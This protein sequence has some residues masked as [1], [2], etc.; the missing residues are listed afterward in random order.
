MPSAALPPGS[1]E[2]RPL[3]LL[4]VRTKP[5]DLPWLAET[6]ARFMA[7][8]EI[9]QV[10][11]LSNALWRLGQERFDSVLLDLEVKDRAALEECRRQ[12]GQVAGLPVLNLQ[13]DGERALQSVLPARSRMPDRADPGQE[14]ARPRRTVRLPWQRRPR[15]A[16]ASSSRPEVA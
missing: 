6:I 10:V 4:L 5:G 14:R 2:D 7:P 13:D 16:S 8:I 9:V 3:R 12:I 11:G 15:H 1:G